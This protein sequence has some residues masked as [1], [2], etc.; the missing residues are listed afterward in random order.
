MRNHNRMRSSE[1]WRFGGRANEMQETGSGR[2]L[3]PGQQSASPLFVSHGLDTDG[4][5]LPHGT[6]YRDLQRTPGQEPK[7]STQLLYNL[8][9]QRSELMSRGDKIN[10]DV[11][12]FLWW[13]AKHPVMNTFIRTFSDIFNRPKN[14]CGG[15]TYIEVL[16]SLKLV[17]DFFSDFVVRDAQVLPDVAIFVHQGHVVIVDV[18]KLGQRN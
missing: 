3:L 14:E 5:L 12:L 8:N 15:W 6:H 16:T 17:P 1:G 13:L 7:Y 18:D 10:K 9:L 11:I 4:T 2:S